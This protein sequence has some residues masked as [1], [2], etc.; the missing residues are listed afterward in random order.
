MLPYKIEHFSV[1][2]GLYGWAS[3]QLDITGGV[4]VKQ[5]RKGNVTVMFPAA[6]EP[7]DGCPWWRALFRPGEQFKLLPGEFQRNFDFKFV[8]TC[9]AGFKVCEALTADPS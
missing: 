2:Y 1:N 7:A 4:I 8:L 5:S 9:M 6:T 3:Y